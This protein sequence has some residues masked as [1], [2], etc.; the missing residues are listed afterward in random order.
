MQLWTKTEGGEECA[1]RY[2]RGME[3]M[4]GEVG[5]AQGRIFRF[6]EISSYNGNGNVDASSR[7]QS[8]VVFRRRNNS[9]E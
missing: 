9:N 4:G 5:W 8:Q 7:F 3:R 6:G 1:P 2:A